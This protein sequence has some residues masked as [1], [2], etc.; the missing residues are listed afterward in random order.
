MATT[1]T[2]NAAHVAGGLVAL[3]RPTN[4]PM[5]RLK[6]KNIRPLFSAAVT[7]TWDKGSQDSKSQSLLQGG[8]MRLSSRP[9]HIVH[10]YSKLSH[11]TSTPSNNRLASACSELCT[12]TDLSRY[13]HRVVYPGAPTAHICTTLP[14]TLSTDPRKQQHNTKT[15]PY[16]LCTVACS[17]AGADYCLDLSCHQ[18]TTGPATELSVLATG[19]SQVPHKGRRMGGYCHVHCTCSTK[20]KPSVGK[21]G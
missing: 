10:A 7:T 2:C 15:H 13:S 1:A 14:G 3:D 18:C 9:P 16:C 5:H 21:R 12:G 8:N 11:F 20:T 6:L 4:Q 19:A 17:P